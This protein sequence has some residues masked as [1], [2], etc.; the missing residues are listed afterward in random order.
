[1]V[2]ACLGWGSLIWD[3]RD[4]PIR[5]EWRTDGPSLPVEFARQSVN[6]RI[7]LV[8]AE[9][10]DPIPVLWTALDLA[11]LHEGRQ[12]LALR[13]SIPL[14][15]MESSVGAWSS[16]LSPD[17]SEFQAIAEWADAAGVTG[18]V[19]TALKPKFAGKPIKPSCDQIIDYLANLEGETR[20]LAEE[21][22]RR[23][24]TQVTTSYRQR[25]ERELGWTAA[26]HAKQ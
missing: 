12:A 9:D 26:R 10:T 22:V 14:A 16:S 21:Y 3:P 5:T 8:I 6:G 25:I 2:I 11:S 1:M 20:Q 13:E 17:R 23:A 18:V 4:L 19:W 24:P 15:H 7:T